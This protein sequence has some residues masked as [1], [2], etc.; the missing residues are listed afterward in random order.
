MKTS[1]KQTGPTPVNKPESAEE[2]LHREAVELVKLAKELGSKQL[3]REYEKE[4]KHLQDALEHYPTTLAA[5]NYK[6]LEKLAKGLVQELRGRIATTE[7][8]WQQMTLREK[9]NKVIN[10]ARRWLPDEVLYS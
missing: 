10:A 8:V 5:Q 9:T 2:A 4:V 6:Q 1:C 7:S 3:V